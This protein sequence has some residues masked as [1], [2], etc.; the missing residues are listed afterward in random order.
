MGVGSLFQYPVIFTA[1]FILVLSSSTDPCIWMETS[2]PRSVLP[3]V[4][5]EAYRFQCSLVD[6][7]IYA[8]RLFNLFT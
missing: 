1:F 5:T 6:G 4:L 2:N 8:D 3:R 7:S